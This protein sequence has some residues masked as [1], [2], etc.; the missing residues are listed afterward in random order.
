M[1][2]FYLYFIKNYEFMLT[3]WRLHYVQITDGLTWFYR[4]P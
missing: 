3:D 2:I 4:R 1:N